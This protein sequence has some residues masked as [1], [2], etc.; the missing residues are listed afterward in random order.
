MNEEIVAKIRPGRDGSWLVSFPAIVGAH[1]YGRSLSQLRRRI[2]ELLRL[3]DRDPTRMAIVEVVE[4]PTT[5]KQ[6]VDRTRKERRDLE[7]RS[8]EVQRDLEKTI[9]R[10]QARL[11]LSVR[12]SG[13]L[14]GISPQ[15]VHKLRRRRS[16]A[17]GPSS[18]AANLRK[19]TTAPR[20]RERSQARP[21]ARASGSRS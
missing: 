15:Y 13:D 12:D 2:P 9:G 20:S 19:G 5:L 21:A 8:R 6:A 10:L 14:L 4:L 16:A 3:W 18:S 1:T 11:G 17:Q 7:L